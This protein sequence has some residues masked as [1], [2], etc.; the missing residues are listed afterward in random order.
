MVAPIDLVLERLDG[1]KRHG[2]YF[3]ARSPVREDST[4]SLQIREADDGKVLFKD[5]GGGEV[6][7]IVAAIGLTMSDLFVKDRSG[8][9]QER[10]A[11]KKRVYK[12]PEVPEDAPLPDGAADWFAERGIER[13]T[14]EHFG[15]YTS[16]HYFHKP[17]KEM[18][19]INFPYYRDGIAVNIKHRCA[20]VKDFSMET[21]AEPCWYNLDHLTPDTRTLLIAEGEMDVLA[22][23]QATGI[24]AISPPN[25]SESVSNEVFLSGESLLGDERVRVIL[26]GDMD[27]AGQKMMDEIARRVGKERCARVM[28]PEGCKD[29]NDV[30]RIHGPQR[31]AQCVDGALPLPVDGIIR[32]DDVMDGL[33]DLYANGLPPGESTGIPILD[34]I[35]TVKTGYWTT[36]IASPSAGKSNI[37]D[38]IMVNLAE[39]SDWRFAIASLESPNIPRH[40]ANILPK[41]L[42]KPFREGPTQ[43]MNAEEVETEAK[44]WMNDHFFFIQPE[45]PNIEEILR[46]AKA[47][48]FS[49]GIKGLILDPWNEMEH[50]PQGLNNGDYISRCLTLIRRFCHQHDIHIW[51]VVHPTKLVKDADGQ[52]P[53]PSL[54][55][56]SGSA[57][58]NNKTDYGLCMWRDRINFSAPVLI[59]CD[60]SRQS[61]VATLGTISLG[62]DPVTTRYFDL[63][64]DGS[65]DRDQWRPKTFGERMEESEGSEFGIVGETDDVFMEE[66]VMIDA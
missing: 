12:R 24:E 15:V 54:Y 13:A 40:I 56:A 41:R 34:T 20:K 51:L 39:N 10:R 32:V 47:L 26:A 11:T 14:L 35:Y 31:V 58:F 7:E 63:Q 30:L 37:L 2:D 6:E 38:Q 52:Y 28:W 55:D 42:R 27:D 17:K 3:M 4:P 49:E 18:T 21:D 8:V 36:V 33:W 16:K 23:W 19:S 65:N 25:G 45:E 43:R 48:V 1:V 64:A 5:Y 29:A 46:R 9:M 62:Y 59:K 50:P 57:L 60:K 44:G 22:I 53:M 61:E 66:A